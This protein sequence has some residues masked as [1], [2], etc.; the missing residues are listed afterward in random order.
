M[1]KK[2]RVKTIR[3]DESIRRGNTLTA[4]DKIFHIAVNG[5]E[6]EELLKIC[7]TIISGIAVLA[8]FDKVT[9]ED[10]NY[11]LSFISG[12]VYAMG[13][14]IFKIDNKLFL[15]G[16]KE[17]YDDGSLRQYVEESK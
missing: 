7:D 14:E 2:R 8:S 3:F 4:Y 13:G 16:S 11:M 10:A 12:V 6:Q 15:F 5:T 9:T 1:F 17:A